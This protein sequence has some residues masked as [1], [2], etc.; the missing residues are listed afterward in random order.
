MFTLDQPRGRVD[1]GPKEAA[2]TGAEASVKP[3]PR[4]YREGMGAE[5]PPPSITQ[6]CMAFAQPN[7]KPGDSEASGLEC[8]QQ[9]HTEPG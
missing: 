8:S 6:L 4:P 5:G 3:T 1:S 7:R 2:G 9:P